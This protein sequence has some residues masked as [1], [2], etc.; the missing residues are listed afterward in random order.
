MKFNLKQ[1]LFINN[2]EYQ[3]TKSI[4]EYKKQ[5]QKTKLIAYI[6]IILY[7]TKKTTKN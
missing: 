1:K 7:N 6:Y 2:V 5:K 4:I 3:K